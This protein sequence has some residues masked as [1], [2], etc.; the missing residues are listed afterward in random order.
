MAIAEAQKI[1]ETVSKGSDGAPS[2]VVPTAGSATATP[3]TGS[4]VSG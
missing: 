2:P 1:K 3:S 4:G